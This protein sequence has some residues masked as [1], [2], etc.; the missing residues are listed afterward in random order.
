MSKFSVKKFFIGIMFASMIVGEI[1]YSFY[2][3]EQKSVETI[4]KERDNAI[5]AFRKSPD[6][7]KRRESMECDIKQ[8]DA[9]TDSKQHQND[10]AL[11]KN[12]GKVVI[13]VF[14][15]KIRADKQ[16]KQKIIEKYDQWEKQRI[17][18]INSDFEPKIKAASGL[19]SN[20]YL[21]MTVSLVA[22][23]LAYL[24]TRQ[25]D[26]WRWVLLIAAFIAQAFVSNVI[27]DGTII[28]YGS[29]FKAFLTAGVFFLCVPLAYHFGIID[30]NT[31]IPF[32]GIIIS[33]TKHGTSVTVWSKDVEGWKKAILTLC[34]ERARN[35][36]KGLMAE[37][38]RDFDVNKGQVHRA[39]KLLSEG[40]PLYVP[41]KLLETN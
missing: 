4:K 1:L 10:A 30:Y 9:S 17:D 40:K 8:L 7:V 20:I 24:A 35:N 6:A 11:A 29:E 13:N 33:Q 31:I 41:R 38:A 34:N 18:A 36:G 27:Y 5:E 28:K 22:I 23:L 21:S 26:N 19:S 12:L 25:S 15:D 37:I 3:N 32:G 2:S 16:E 39:W 14:D